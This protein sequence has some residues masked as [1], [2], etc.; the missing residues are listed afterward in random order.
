LLRLLRAIPVADLAAGLH[1]LAGVDLSA[2]VTE[3]A[4]TY[5]TELFSTPDAPGSMMAARA[6]TPLEDPDTVAAS[7]AA[8]AGDLLSATEVLRSS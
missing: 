2:E 6:A 8:L 5:L 7:C 1:R 4:I 3:E